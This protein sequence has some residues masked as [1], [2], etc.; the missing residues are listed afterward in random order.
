MK[1][2]FSEAQFVLAFLHNLFSYYDRSSLRYTFKM[3]TQ[4]E[5]Y[6]VG[7]DAEIRLN[8]KVQPLYFQFKI[9]EFLSRGSAREYDDFSKPYYRFKIWPANRSPQHNNLVQLSRENAFVV[10]CAPLF[11]TIAEFDNC[12]HNILDYS[13]MVPCRQLPKN[14]GNERHFITY[15]Y[16]CD[17][18]YWHSEQESISVIQG[19]QLAEY[20]YYYKTYDNIINYIDSIA[21]YTDYQSLFGMDLDRNSIEDIKHYRTGDDRHLNLLKRTVNKI[22]CQIAKQLL[23]KYN[24]ILILKM[25]KER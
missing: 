22:L 15:T 8:C 24:L 18:G 11:C 25:E 14:H 10:Y 1:S 3:P 4:I 17:F 2:E 6:N 21:D 12:Q 13:I 20:L 19:P 7:Y 16:D 23:I 9:A 5:E